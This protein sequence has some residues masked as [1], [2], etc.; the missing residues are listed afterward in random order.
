ML[1]FKGGY[2]GCVVEFDLS[3]EKEVRRFV[4]EDE[5]LNQDLQL[6]TGGR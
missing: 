1:E 4:N 3:S 2:A 5:L 6:Y